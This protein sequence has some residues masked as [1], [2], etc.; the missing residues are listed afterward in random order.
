MSRTFRTDRWNDYKTVH[1]GKQRRNCKCG[2]C[3]NMNY[4]NRYGLTIIE[5]LKANDEHL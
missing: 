2:W 4:R 1:D 5:N 3:V